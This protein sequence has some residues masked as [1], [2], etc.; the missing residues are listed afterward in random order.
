MMQGLVI[1][2]RPSYIQHMMMP[3]SVLSNITMNQKP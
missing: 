3:D 1:G 2:W